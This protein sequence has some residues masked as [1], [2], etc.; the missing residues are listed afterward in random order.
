MAWL[1]LVRSCALHTCCCPNFWKGRGL[2]DADV[3]R[4]TG[5]YRNWSS[6][7]FQ[8]EERQEEWE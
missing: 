3:P 4:N 2:Q 1:Q 7:E 6:K 5:K 8:D